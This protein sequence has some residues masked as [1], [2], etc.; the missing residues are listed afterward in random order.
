MSWFVRSLE[1]GDWIVAGAYG[2]AGP[3]PRWEG[4]L[5]IVAIVTSAA[6]ACYG[7]AVLLT[8]LASSPAVMFAGLAPSWIVIILAQRRKP[9]FIAVT[10]RYLYVIRATSSGWPK[11]VLLRTPI[12]AVRAST[13]QR[14]GLSKRSVVR[15]SGPG[16]VA[17]ELLFVAQGKWRK[18]LSD[19]LA[20]LGASGAVI[21]PNLTGPA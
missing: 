12:T 11:G 7:L 17:G 10:T 1:P 6:T 19:M 21:A 2:Q 16:F 13:D 5:A 3:A 4:A 14:P 15:L 18:D 20:T 9:T 8:D